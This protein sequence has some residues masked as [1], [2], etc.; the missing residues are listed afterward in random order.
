MSSLFRHIE[1]LWGITVNGRPACAT[2]T[3]NKVTITELIRRKKCT[4]SFGGKLYR[5]EV[6]EME[7]K[8]K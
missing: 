1:R 8:P 7:V 4:I 5:V 6:K 2:G 3:T